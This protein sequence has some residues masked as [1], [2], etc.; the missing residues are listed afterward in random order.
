MLEKGLLKSE[1]LYKY[2]LETSVYPREA[3]PLKELRAITANHPNCL[4]ATAPDAGQLIRMV[5]S[6]LNAK[7]TIEIG[8]FTGYS[9]LLTA[10]TIPDDGKIIAIDQDREAY[11]YG[12]PVIKRAGVE[13][14]ITF[15]ES[16]ALMALDHLLEDNGNKN[17]LDFAYVDADKK[18]YK[19]YHEKLLQL[20]KV[21]GIIVYDNTLWGGTVVM[22]EES[23]IDRMKPGRQY[24]IEFNA[25]LA[26]DDQVHI[27]H[28]PVGDGI[29]ICKRLK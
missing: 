23:V 5:L 2:I 4:M 18:S 25:F 28:V 27:S 6:L 3:E 29:T 10:L 8:V 21:G 7:R 9:L 24:T 17:S 14:K 20:I 15:V 12:L 19:K 16:D 13:H 11:E 22:P 1:E 26:L